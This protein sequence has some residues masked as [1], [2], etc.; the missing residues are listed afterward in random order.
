MSIVRTAERL[1]YN[2]SRGRSMIDLEV[3]AKSKMPSLE[4]RGTQNNC[5]RVPSHRGSGSLL[6]KVKGLSELVAGGVHIHAGTSCDDTISQ[7]GHY[8]NTDVLKSGG[9]K[10][11]GDAWFNMASSLAPTGTGYSTDEDGE[12][13]AYFFFN[14]GFGY[15]G[16]VGHAVVIHDEVAPPLGNGDYA[17][18]ACG[19]LE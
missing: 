9:P 2:I 13:V 5:L 6:M 15:N 17:R 11:N 7:G 18:I 3:E 12:G 4:Q 16:N 19:I 10:D 14:N 8:W 1:T